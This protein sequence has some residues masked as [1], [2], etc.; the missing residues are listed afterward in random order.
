MHEVD[1]SSLA[2]SSRLSP[3]VSA[4]MASEDE[5]DG[6]DGDNED[7]G[8]SDDQTAHIIALR[9]R[10]SHAFSNPLLHL[11]VK[12]QHLSSPRHRPL[13]RNPLSKCCLRMHCKLTRHCS[14]ADESRSTFQITVA[15]GEKWYHMMSTKICTN[16]NLPSTAT[17]TT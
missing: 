8:L 3:P 11:H 4:A 6:D 9:R 7:L 2:R 5:D 16:S 17:C 13:K 10:S 1:F 14:L 12:S 15:S